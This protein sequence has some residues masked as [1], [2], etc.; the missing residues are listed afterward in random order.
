MY[1]FF[2]DLE[3]S[4]HSE[5]MQ[6]CLKDLKRGPNYKK[7]IF[8]EIIYTFGITSRRRS[9]SQKGHGTYLPRNIPASDNTTFYSLF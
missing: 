1:T 3:S 6:E 2:V 9:E 4:L 7:V 8:V 5:E